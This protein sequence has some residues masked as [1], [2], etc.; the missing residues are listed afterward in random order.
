[1]SKKLII[2]CGVS[3]SGKSTFAKKLCKEDNSFLRINRDDIRK[4]LVGDLDEYYQRENLKTCEDMVTDIENCIFEL[5]TFANRNIVIDNTNLNKKYIER[6]L[7]LASEFKYEVEYK[8]FDVDLNVAK[9][10][11]VGRDFNSVANIHKHVDNIEKVKYIE[12]QLQQYNQIKKEH[13]SKDIK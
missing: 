3:G 10:R 12:K 5:C 11:V 2:C 9:R 7:D 1:M 8:F 13:E 4:T 6:W